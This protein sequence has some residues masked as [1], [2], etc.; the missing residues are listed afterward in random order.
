MHRNRF[1]SVTSFNGEVGITSKN[2]RKLFH[3]LLIFSPYSLKD[4]TGVISVLIVI[5]SPG[6]SGDHLPK[7]NQFT[8]I[9][10]YNCSKYLK[11]AEE[12]K[13]SEGECAAAVSRL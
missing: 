6:S 13:Q 3:V 4:I 12:G 1:R 8:P 2:M 5:Y 7:Y 9:V 10:K 11:S